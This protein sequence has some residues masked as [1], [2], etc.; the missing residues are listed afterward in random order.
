[1]SEELVEQR[2]KKGEL[3]MPGVNR[4]QQL[5]DVAKLDVMRPVASRMR[6]RYK[7]ILELSRAKSSKVMRGQTAVWTTINPEM[8]ISG[9]NL[10]TRNGVGTITYHRYK[11]DENGNKKAKM[12]TREV[13]NTSG[14]LVK[15]DVGMSYE[16]DCLVVETIEYMKPIKVEEIKEMV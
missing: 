8:F 6:K 13:R 4:L 10:S 15:V 16:Y 1:M 5:K 11:T 3:R 2:T 9:L 7:E 12:Q 14:D